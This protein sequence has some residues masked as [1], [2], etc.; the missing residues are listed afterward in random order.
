MSA[1]QRPRQRITQTLHRMWDKPQQHAARYGRLAKGAGLIHPCSCYTER[2]PAMADESR[3]FYSYYTW[4]NFSRIKPIEWV[5]KESEAAFAAEEREHL[6]ENGVINDGTPADGGESVASA[7]TRLQKRLGAMDLIFYGVGST[8]GAGIYSLIGPGL[9]KA[10]LF[11][12]CGRRTSDR[13]LFPRCAMLKPPWRCAPLQAQPCCS[14]SSLAQSPVCSRAWR[15]PSSQP[16]SLLLVRP[17]RY[18][19]AAASFHV[20][21]IHASCFSPC[22]TCIFIPVPA[23]FGAV[24]CGGPGRPSSS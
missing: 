1:R 5:L 4:N 3:P 2:L 9:Q 12:C 24:S 6:L 10:G 14:L 7:P 11:A 17:T 15:I 20:V 8:V 22:I 16:A 18:C 13:R 21:T 23:F 19:V